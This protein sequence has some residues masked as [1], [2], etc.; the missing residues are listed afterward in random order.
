MEELIRTES[1]WASGARTKII[2]AATTTFAAFVTAVWFV[3][4]S[5]MQEHLAYL[6]RRLIDAEKRIAVHMHDDDPE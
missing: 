4:V 1:D 3:I 5:P 6:E 2:G